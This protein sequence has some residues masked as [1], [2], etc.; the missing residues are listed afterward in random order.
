MAGIDS[1]PET[2]S[3]CNNFHLKTQFDKNLRVKCRA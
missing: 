1:N 2:D 3:R